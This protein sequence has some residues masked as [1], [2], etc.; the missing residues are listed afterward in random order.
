MFQHEIY[1]KYHYADMFHPFSGHHSFLEWN[2]N[3]T[4]WMCRCWMQTKWCQNCWSS[5][6]VRLFVYCVCR[7]FLFF[8]AIDL[9]RIILEIYTF[10]DKQFS[11][12]YQLRY[13][14]GD[15]NSKVFASALD[16]CPTWHVYWKCSGP[17]GFRL[18]ISYQDRPIS[19]KYK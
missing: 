13:G 9:N 17:W 19:R 11:Y 12:F 14:L 8:N 4:R 3:A 10:S 2:C 18:T 7:W 15:A 6:F 16:V 1:F 5:G